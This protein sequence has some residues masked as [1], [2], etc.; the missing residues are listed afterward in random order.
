MKA[1]TLA[2]L[3]MVTLA[4]NIPTASASVSDWQQFHCDTAR[5]RYSTSDAPDTN[6]TAW[7]SDDIGASPAVADGMVF[8]IDGGRVYAFGPAIIWHGDVTLGSGTF[9]VTA[10]SG[11]EYTINRT[12]ALAALIRAAECDGFNYSIS[13]AWY[14]TYGSLHFDMIN[15]RYESGYDGW[16]YWVNYPDD[17]GPMVGANSCE[18]VDGDVV[19]WY[20]GE[21]MGATPDSSDMLVQIEVRLIT[22]RGDLNHDGAITPA[23]AIIALQMAVRGEWQEAA[24]MNRDG[25][26]TSLDAT[27]ILQTTTKAPTPT[28]VSPAPDWSQFH[29]DP[30]R[31]GNTSGDAPLTD[32]L[33][34]KMKPGEGYIGCGASVLDGR[35]YVSNWPTMGQSSNL[36]LHC[37]DESDGSIIWSNS[38][39]GRGGV[40]TPAI[41]GGRVFAGSLGP[42]GT[43]PGTG[44]LYCID[45]S[46]GATI[47]NITIEPD[48]QWWGLASSPLIYDD[49]VY[50]VSFSDRTLHAVDFDGNE[51]WNHS[52]AGGS[53]V[54]MSAATDGS[55]IF[56]GGG[57]AMN[58]VDIEAHTEVWN[59]SVSGKVTT[60]PATEDGIVYFATDDP[61]KRLYAIDIATGAE[62]W[63]R[64]LY[65][66][67]SS[68]AISDGKIY[69]GD[70]EK[71]INCFNATDGDEIWN[72]SVDG[73]ILSSPAVAGETV[74]FGVN[75]GDGTIYALNATDGSVRWSYNTGNYIMSPP[76]ISDGMM[77]IGSDTGYLYAFGTPE[78]FWEGSAV[79][80]KGG[81]LNLTAKGTNYTINRTTALGAFAKAA[82]N[83][84]FNFTVN[85]SSTAFVDSV[86]GVSND[87]TEGTHWHYWVNYPA[88]PKPGVG[89]NEFELNA[90]NTARDVVTF[91][92][93]KS[94]TTPEN[95]TM[96]IEITTQVIERKPEVI[97][98][99]VERHDFIEDAAVS[100]NL[101]VTLLHPSE[102]ESGID[103]TR[104]DLIFLEHINGETAENL[105]DPVKAADGHKIP[106]I[107]IH[108]EWYD[109][110]FGNS[111][112]SDEYPL[113]LQYWDNY[114][115]E[116]IAR[117]LTYLEVNFCG[118]IG[119]IE[120][121]VPIPKAHIHHP[122]THELFFNTTTYLEWYAN[123]TGY[124]YDPDN[125]TVGIANWHESV[126]SPEISELIHTL[127]Q[128]GANVISIGFT[129]TSDL[130]RFYM[131]NN[132]T[133]VDVVI[134][135]KSFRINMGDSDQGI[136]DLET[137][138]VP[139]M[140]GIRLYYMSPDEWYN[141][142]SH[143]IS[144]LDLGFQVGLPELDGII[145][146]IV[147]SGK[148]EN[149]T[150]YQPIGEQINRTCDRAIGWGGLGRTPDE[151]KRIAMIYYNHGGGKDNLAACYANVP[152]SL[153]NI[154]TAMKD[155]GYNVTTDVPNETELVNL[156]IHQGTN[157]GTWADGELDRM[158]DAGNA[159]L[160]PVGNYTRWFSELAAERQAEVIERWGE[161]PGEIMVWTNDTTGAQYFVIPKL[162]FGNVILA[163]QPTRGWLQNNTVLYHD[164]DIPP[165]HQYIAFYL[166]LKQEQKSGGFGADAIMHFGKHGTQEWLPGKESGLSSEDC[167]PAILIQDMPVIYP[168]IVD[169]IAEGTQ[170]KRRG[171]ATMITHLTP[172]I[173]ASGLYGNLTNL[174]Q[175]VALYVD[176]GNETVREECRNTIISQCRKLHLDDDM[177]VDLSET[178][179]TLMNETLFD[180]FVRKLAEHLYEIKTDFMPY[181]L[182]TFGEPPVGEPMISM[183]ISMLRD[184]YKKDVA[185]MI[186]YD[187]YPNP[188]QID[189]ERELD[190]CTAGLLEEVII[191]GTD[192]VEAQEIAFDNRS[193]ANLSRHLE[194]GVL[195]ADDI[196]NC[197]VE[198]SSTL[199][200]FDGEY[201][202]PS[203]ADDPIRNPNVLP[204]GRNFYSMN[205]RAIPT[206]E[207]WDTG[208]KMADALIER[209]REDHNGEYP[210]K[211]AIV[212]WAWA[213]TDYGVVE[214]EILY[215]V[216]ARPLWDGYGAVY[217]VE[218]IDESEL[219]RPRIDVMVIPS[220]LHRDV[221]PEKLK[222][223]DRAIRLAAAANDTIYDNYVRENSVEIFEALNAT[224]NYTGPYPEEDAR[225]LSVSRIFLEAP[226][227]YGPNLDSVVAA[228]G[229]WNSS[230]VIGETYVERMHHI[231]GD[232][233]WG[234]PGEEV[235]MLNLAQIDA[236]VHN[237]NSNLYGFIDNDDVF[238]YVGG[239]VRAYKVVTGNEFDSDNIYVTDNSDPTR[240][241]AVSSLHE[242]LYMELRTRYLNTKWIDGMMGE[243]YAGAGA[244]S[245]FFEYLWGW[246]ATCPDLISDD[247]WQQVYD[248]YVGDGYSLGLDRFFEGDTAYAYQSMVGRMLET[249]RKGY[250]T[251]GDDVLRQMVTEYVESIA[252]T[253]YVTC[254]HHTCGNPLLDEYI[255]GLISTLGITIDQKT[256]DEYDR[257]MDEMRSATSSETS[258]CESKSDGGGNSDGDGTYPPEW[259]N[260]TEKEEDGGSGMD[261]TMP[262][263]QSGVSKPSRPSDYVEGTEMNVETSK[264]FS[265][266]M[267]LSGAPMIGVLL[268]ILSI[269]LIGIGS[270]FKRG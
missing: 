10:E 251:P 61:D 76:S 152:P 199:G 256:M 11:K 240:D 104:Y 134:C 8:T 121:P 156:M 90:E 136:R 188:L 197:T 62:V 254:C 110:I 174:A 34:W 46:D 265:T 213:M 216:G 66:S 50:V 36:G 2:I 24:D 233:V 161:P 141:E 269:A 169:N 238:Q 111:N 176:C 189:K 220:G 258:E 101:N 106:I 195:F 212:L 85:N 130:K 202:S 140:R 52:K 97:F 128:K 244:I 198:V 112:V 266:K 181:G 235:F 228:S 255:R 55:R 160:I 224:G 151:E 270:R 179:E 222:L 184:G 1:K 74:Y 64:H 12:C 129:G 234:I 231:Y 77:F 9:N 146:P 115:E 208:K 59:Y 153:R 206:E 230:S 248:V 162:S 187:D 45:A 246:E 35:V 26:V 158:V 164:K 88:D 56:F 19:T 108:S 54:Y 14:D 237:T 131:V 190:N 183:I 114:A 257:I 268:V 117:L 78:K 137:L 29:H 177:D 100:S 94:W 262:A 20:W 68:P 232:G 165:H 264:K 236:I 92:Y 150:V 82:G 250:W 41:A 204:T 23:D 144:I 163:P 124:Q 145:D 178:S 95:S 15:D 84:D 218:L 172:P 16:L 148:G 247:V 241:P 221:F 239:L 53:N 170:A 38:L 17:P 205:P 180:E 135:T 118:L 159:T 31:T 102:V 186:G 63:S 7:I 245:K 168:Y 27:M 73:A 192:I 80:L 91:Y 201:I 219:G 44:E 98:I 215:L 107:C 125:L 142:T 120:V 138:N 155:A 71:K 51:L 42:Y 109:G 28:S 65:G 119:D 157:I 249:A 49:M 143:G 210:R 79:L 122:D 37:L 261:V 116:N 18:L 260:E 93:G 207:A 81:T 133:I 33:I 3:T 139:V 200:G 113:I 39:G 83:G 48:P 182:H 203:Q 103:L 69:I 147:I 89:A 154:L 173:V 43:G 211:P 72:K 267:S 99:T 225:Y 259:S 166:W 30:E 253:G 171:S 191:N 185:R 60:T 32:A 105:Q 127:E 40:S 243:G 87:E 22:E 214:S 6:H 223:I 57:N 47:W 194:R 167:W 227:T 96:V 126:R 132:S 123:N 226:G 196:A 58:C 86:A 4:L 252:D 70:R 149:D 209:Y 67:V 21:G 75:T 217:D 25:N 193:S 5:A 175:T 263:S 242:V 229:T 13:D